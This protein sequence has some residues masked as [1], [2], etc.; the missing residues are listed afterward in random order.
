MD[1]HR[2]A[3]KYKKQTQPIASD[4]YHSHSTTAEQKA[5]PEGIASELHLTSSA[6]PPKFGND[7]GYLPDGVPVHM[8]GEQQNHPETIGVDPHKSFLLQLKSH[9]GL[10][11]TTSLM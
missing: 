11:W 8:A 10:M 3:A 9:F 4:D 6:L 2:V 5:N 7:V 1:T